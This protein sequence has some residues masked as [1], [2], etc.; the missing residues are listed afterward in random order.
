[1]LRSGLTPAT[2]EQPNPGFMDGDEATA[3]HTRATSPTRVDVDVEVRYAE[4]DAQGVVHHAN[5]LVWFELARTR[6]CAMSGHPYPEIEELGYQLVVTGADVRYRGGARYGDHVRVGCWIARM[7]SRGMS[8]AYEVRR[9]DELLADGGTD[10]V[11]ID[12]ERRRVCRAPDG[13]RQAFR[14]LAGLEDDDAT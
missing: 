8:F 14:R 12:V 9:D 7:E 4:T 5:Y 1:M 13:L 11:W 3:E 2:R 6:L 10:H